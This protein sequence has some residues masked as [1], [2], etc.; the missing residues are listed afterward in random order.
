MDTKDVIWILGEWT[1]LNREE[2]GKS[3]T[4]TP[5]T[6][7]SYETDDRNYTVRSLKDIAEK[8]D[9]DIVFEKRE[10]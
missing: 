4:K 10:K 2:F 9:I 8:H 1:E 7:K 3:I 6:I 5:T